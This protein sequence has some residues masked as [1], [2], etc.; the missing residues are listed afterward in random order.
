MM[1]VDCDGTDVALV[2]WP[3]EV[4]AAERLARVGRPRVL[5]VAPGVE[6]PLV[7]DPLEDWVRV[8]VQ[9]VDVDVRAHRLARIDRARRERSLPAGCSARPPTELARSEGTGP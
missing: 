2:P 9:P 8:P 6:P 7:T 4:A 5:L 1:I 3:D